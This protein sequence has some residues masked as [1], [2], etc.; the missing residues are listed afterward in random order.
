[1]EKDKNQN[2]IIFKDSG[3]GI[4]VEVK[5]NDENLW[6]NLNQLSQLFKRDKS[7]ISRHIKNIYESKELDRSSTVAFFAT[8]QNEGKRQVERNIEFFNLDLIIS[9]GYRVNSKIGTK[10]RIWSNKVLKNYLIKG[11]TVNQKKLLSAKDSISELYSILTEIKNI[12]TKASLSNFDKQSF[13]DLILEY[14]DS[15]NLI[16]MFDEGELAIP[17]KL[18]PNKFNL[19]YDSAINEINTLRSSLQAGDLFGSLKDEGF[20]S[21]IGNIYQ[22]YNGNDLYSSAEVKAA[23][24]LYLIIKNH[25]FVDGNKRIGSYF[26]VRFLDANKL[27]RKANGEKII[28]ENTLVA[29]AIMVAQS[30]RSHKEVIINLIMNLIKT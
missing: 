27:L 17:K 3:T 24:L 14:T 8:V 21:A 16:K 19:E 18:T 25:P 15:L 12:S 7:A 28:S 9:L 1:M 23:N 6:L 10:F 5:F 20:K 26:F 13:V 11:Y 4:E 2:F 22:T 30:D 29:L